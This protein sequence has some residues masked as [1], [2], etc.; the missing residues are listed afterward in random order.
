MKSQVNPTTHRSFSFCFLYKA[1]Y[2]K[3]RG[4]LLR[5][6]CKEGAYV[7]IQ[8]LIHLF[9]K[10]LKNPKIAKNNEIPKKN[11]FFIYLHHF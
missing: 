9:D 3:H 4:V 7:A 1:Y 5:K 8:F 11:M 2:A 6:H 10:L